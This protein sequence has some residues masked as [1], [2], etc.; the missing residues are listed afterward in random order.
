MRKGSSHFWPGAGIQ[1]AQAQDDVHAAPWLDLDS[2][3]AV[4]AGGLTVCE[5]ASYVS[6]TIIVSA[7]E[8]ENFLTDCP[9]EFSPGVGAF[10]TTTTRLHMHKQPQRQDLT[11]SLVENGAGPCKKHFPFHWRIA[12]ATRLL[13]HKLSFASDITRSLIKGGAGPCKKHFPLTFGPW[14][15][16]GS[17]EGGKKKKRRQRRAYGAMLGNNL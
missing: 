14:E 16:L 15:V 1:G 4:S 11:R 9:P 10:C 13:L 3:P 8:T 7:S 5:P 6:D 17:M 12:R 2:P